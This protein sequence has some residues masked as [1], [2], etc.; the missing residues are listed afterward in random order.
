VFPTVQRLVAAAPKI[1][2]WKVTAFRPRA[3]GVTLEMNNIKLSASTMMVQIRDRGEKLDIVVHLSGGL[4]AD[5]QTKQAVY[6]LL[7]ALLGE[8]DVETRV[9]G[10]DIVTGAPPKTAVPLVKLRDVVDAK[11]K[12]AAP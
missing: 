4:V 9:A 8:Y 2:G 7:D 5:Q 12:R 10:I 1:P 11:K 6:L 3:D